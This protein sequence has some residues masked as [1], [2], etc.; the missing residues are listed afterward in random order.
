MRSAQVEAPT[1]RVRPVREKH[2]RK[3]NQSDA[4]PAPD[5][6]FRT[7][8]RFEGDDDELVHPSGAF[9]GT[10]PAAITRGQARRMCRNFDASGH[11]NHSG[12]GSTLWV[13]LEHCAKVD[14]ACNLR[15]IPGIGYYVER[16]KSI[17]DGLV[18]RMS[19]ET[20]YGSLQG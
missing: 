11:S 6:D 2:L 10:Q 8:E 19:V 4:G 20:G 12:R 17:D 15:A 18:L 5:Q 1:A 3:L 14:I 13:I 9:P 16:T 7:S